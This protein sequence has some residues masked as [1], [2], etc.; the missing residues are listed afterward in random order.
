MST[1]HATSGSKSSREVNADKSVAWYKPDVGTIPEAAV[2]LLE[3]YSKISPKDLI[4]HVSKVVS[5]NCWIDLSR[6]GANANIARASLANRSI[7]MHW[8]VDV[9]S[10]E[11]KSESSI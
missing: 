4:T 6:H 7:S 3:Q 2:R 10:I 5:L 8:R 11:H 1:A 9:P